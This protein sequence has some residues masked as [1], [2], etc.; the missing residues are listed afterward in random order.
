MKT[1]AR[2][3]ALASSLLA[4]SCALYPPGPER[5][6][7]AVMG[8]VPYRAREEPRFERMIERINAEPYAF[9]VHVGD[10]KGT[11]RCSDEL[12]L[13]RKAQFER[14]THPFIYTPGDNEWTDCRDPEN[15]AFDPLERLGKLRAIFFADGFSMGRRRIA[16]EAQPGF[17]E[18]RMWRHGHVVFATIHVVGSDNNRG[19]NAAGDRDADARDAANLAWLRTAA[20][21]ARGERALVILAQANLWWG[22]ERVFEPYRNALAALAQWLRRPVLFVHGDTHLYRADMPFVD[23]SG[24]PVTNPMRLE[25]YGSPFVGWVTVEVDVS[26]PDVFSFEPKMEAPFFLQ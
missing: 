4:A 14:S 20:E 19:Y 22:N 18:N 24:A 13:H 17:P 9:V 3:L 7:F 15:G 21:R 26:R 1:T 5:F 6:S 2:A 8:D 12:Y 16:L 11:G 25:T 23:A 10:I